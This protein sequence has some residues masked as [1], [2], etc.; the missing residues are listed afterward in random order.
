[1]ANFTDKLRD[2]AQGQ[3]PRATSLTFLSDLSFEDRSTFRQIWPELPTERRRRIVDLLTTMGE[4]NI[5]L[6]FRPVFLA[7]L[8]DGDSKVRIAAVEG[9]VE[10]NSKLLMSK[11]ISLLQNDP[12][13]PVREAAAIALGRFTCRAQCNQLGDDAPRLRDALLKS[14]RTEQTDVRRRAIEALGYLNGDAEVQDLITKAYKR[15]GRDAESAVFA[16]GHSI[17]PQWQ[18]TILDELESEHPGMRYEAARAAGEMTLEDALP[19]LV[20]MV[21]DKDSEVRLAAIWALGQI[22]GKPAAEALARASKSAEPAL[23]EAA[24][25][26]MDEIVFPAN[27]FNIL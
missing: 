24:K 2:L 5:D 15:G 6:Y 18:Q 10:D 9:L 8:S 12:D 21:D 20:R 27:P 14:A 3:E 25:E 23:R 7:M 17:D 11:L 4:D 16:M 19:F 1:M 26:A 13:A 22:G